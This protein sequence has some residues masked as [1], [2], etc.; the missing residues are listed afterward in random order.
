MDDKK[1][2]YKLQSDGTIITMVPNGRGANIPVTLHILYNTVEFTVDESEFPKLS[3]WS[4]RISLFV[5]K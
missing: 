3:N 4:D 2:K 5:G 1:F